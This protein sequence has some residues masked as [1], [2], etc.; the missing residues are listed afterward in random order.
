MKTFLFIILHLFS[1]LTVAAESPLEL[2]KASDRARGG[3]KDGVSWSVTISTEGE[4]KNSSHSFAVKAKG[5]DAYV[6]ATAPSRSKG[7]VFIF[8][9]RNMWFFKP[10]LRK[11]VSISARQKLTG[12]AANG[13]IAT[14]HYSRDY[15]PTIIG[16]EKINGEPTQVLMLQAKSNEVTYDKIKYWISTKTKLAIKAEFMTLQGKAF[17]NGTFE[18]NNVLNYQ[19]KTF[20][21]ISKMTIQDAKFTKKVSVITYGTPKTESIDGSLF[22]INNL[23]R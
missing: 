3:I 1:L 21:F 12:Q 23:R 11:P 5:D 13:D 17:K 20:P 7:E 4:N 18:Y 10:S 16:S 14:T 19:G 2:L 6:E 8:N 9:N 22:N 15:T